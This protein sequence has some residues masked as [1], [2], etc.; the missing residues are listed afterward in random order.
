MMMTTGS[1]TFVKISGLSDNNSFNS[2]RGMIEEGESSD[3]SEKS[4]SPLGYFNHK[5][6]II[7]QILK[8]SFGGNS[9]TTVIITCKP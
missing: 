1:M 2:I 7:Y 5:N 9:K 8:E 3:K 4:L 6:P